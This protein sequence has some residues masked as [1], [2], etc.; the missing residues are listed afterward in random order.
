[1]YIEWRLHVEICDDFQTPI[2][3]EW[4][5]VNVRFVEYSRLGCA[6][7]FSSVS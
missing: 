7:T 3:D 2:K 4:N 6:E 1:L 5:V